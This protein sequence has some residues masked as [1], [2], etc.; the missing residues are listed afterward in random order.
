MFVVFDLDGTL[1]NCEHCLHHIKGDEKPTPEQWDAFF[2]ACGDDKPIP[3]TIEVLKAL[4][5]AGHRVEIWSAR[6]D[7]VAGKTWHWT[8]AHVV[9]GMVVRLRKKGDHRND[10]ILK[11]EWIAEHGKPDLVFEDRERVVRMWR[12]MSVPCFQVAEGAF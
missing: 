12:Q 6:S 7:Q 10:D 8:G 3:H 2:A 9:L 11:A 1:A 4:R 5:S